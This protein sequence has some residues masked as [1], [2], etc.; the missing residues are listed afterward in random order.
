MEMLDTAL[1]E[2]DLAPQRRSETETDAALHLC[3]DNIGIDRG[4]AIDGAYDALN[5]R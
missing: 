2:R 3:A 1:D 5:A 4:P